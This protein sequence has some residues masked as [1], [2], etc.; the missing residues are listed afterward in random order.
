MKMKNR[1][2]SVRANSGR[3]AED[4]ADAQQKRGDV[5]LKTETNNGRNDETAQQ[6]PM[7]LPST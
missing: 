4:T 2:G 7:R 3:T 6:R 1:L 5:D